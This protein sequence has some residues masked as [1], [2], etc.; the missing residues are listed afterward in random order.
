MVLNTIVLIPLNLAWNCINMLNYGVDR[1]A[2]GR[3]KVYATIFLW[4]SLKE[5]VYML[6]TWGLWNSHPRRG[7]NPWHKQLWGL[8]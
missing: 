2:S 3:H 4:K 5:F 7:F 8:I 6:N 1:S